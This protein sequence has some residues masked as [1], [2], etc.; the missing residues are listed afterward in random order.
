MLQYTYDESAGEGT[1]AFVIDTGI[2]TTH[3][4]SLSPT[5]E[6]GQLYCSSFTSFMYIICV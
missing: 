3:P 6:F 5:D 2:D 4:V 1:C